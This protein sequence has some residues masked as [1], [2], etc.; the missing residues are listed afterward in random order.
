M[1]SQE[2]ADYAVSFAVGNRGCGPTRPRSVE[3][4]MTCSRQT[5]IICK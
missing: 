2:D 3:E 4:I 1:G 5:R